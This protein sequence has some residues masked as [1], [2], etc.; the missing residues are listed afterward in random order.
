[1]RRAATAVPCLRRPW[2][3]RSCRQGRS[4]RY[5]CRGRT[6][7][8]ANCRGR[9]RW[10]SPGADMP[11]T[12]RE[13]IA[14]RATSRP[15]RVRS[16]PRAAAKRSRTRH[17]AIAARASP[18]EP[19][20]PRACV[21]AARIAHDS[22]RELRVAGSKASWSMPGRGDQ[23]VA[24]PGRH[25]ASMITHIRLCQRRAQRVD[26]SLRVSSDLYRPLR[27]PDFYKPL[28]S[29]PSVVLGTWC[30]RCL[31]KNWYPGRW[32]AYR[33]MLAYFVR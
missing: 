22:R 8:S 26:R 4:A 33:S 3:C 6:D 13:V 5:R 7:P 19:H 28:G 31:S 20:L 10:R 12:P 9:W 21:A 11:V 30:F 27:K 32:Y 15:E 18:A 17:Q 2:H 29:D 16:P 23:P 24:G 25:H 1:M 14:G